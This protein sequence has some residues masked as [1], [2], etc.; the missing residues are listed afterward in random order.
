ME[1]KKL[2]RLVSAAFWLLVLALVALDTLHTRGVRLEPPPIALGSGQA[3]S[4]GHC[5][6][7]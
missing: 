1:S 5:S 3:A 4:G 6:G 2:F 7:R